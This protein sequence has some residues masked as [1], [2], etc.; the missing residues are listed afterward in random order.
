MKQ[1]DKFKDITLE[2]LAHM[3]ATGFAQMATKEDLQEL[4]SEFGELR[5]EM[6]AGFAH[7]SIEMEKHIGAFRKDYNSLTRRVKKLEEATFGVGN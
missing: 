2:Q 5:N 1:N 7:L 6:H 4:R 3:V